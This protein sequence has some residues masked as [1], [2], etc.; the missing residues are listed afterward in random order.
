MRCHTGHHK[1]AS[2]PPCTLLIRCD[3]YQ[4]TNRR[5]L[6]ED[7]SMLVQYIIQSVVHSEP[8]LLGALSSNL[9]SMC[10]CLHSPHMH[11]PVRSQYLTVGP[12]LA[13][14]QILQHISQHKHCLVDVDRQPSCQGL[15][16]L[17]LC[18]VTK[19][20]TA[21][22]QGSFKRAF[23]CLVMLKWLIRPPVRPAAET[24]LPQFE[25]TS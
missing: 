13:R 23:D 8:C 5:A 14:M 24:Q 11:A 12:M 19:E 20:A 22:V 7:L 10:H 18:G 21:S 16:Y 6:R 25:W 9:I 3:A 4:A 2:N 1:W 15:R 17:Q